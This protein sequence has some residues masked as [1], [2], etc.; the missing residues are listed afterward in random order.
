METALKQNRAFKI[1]ERFNESKEIQPT[2]PNVIEE[3]Q[4]EPS[5]KP[6]IKRSKMEY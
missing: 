1:N 4:P 2:E 5:S 6:K 3:I